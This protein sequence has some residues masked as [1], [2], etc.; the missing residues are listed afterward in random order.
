MASARADSVA[1]S[2]DDKYPIRGTFFGCCAVATAQVTT[3]TK[4]ITESP[5][6]FRFL[7]LRLSSVQVLDFRLSDRAIRNAGRKILIMYSSVNPKSAIENPKLNHLINLFARAIT[8][9]GIVR[10]IFLAVLRFITSSFLS[11]NCL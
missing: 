11:Q 10:P 7:I 3:S 4:A 1:G 6:H 8:S 9:G 5:S 2:N